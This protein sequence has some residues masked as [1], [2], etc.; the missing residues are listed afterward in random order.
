ERCLQKNRDERFSST[1]ELAAALREQSILI[2]VAGTGPTVAPTVKAADTRRLSLWITGLA[3]LFV[4][5][6]VSLWLSDSVRRLVIPSPDRAAVIPK[7]ENVV[8][9]PFHATGQQNLT[10]IF[11]DGLTESVTE[12]LT[13]LTILPSLQIAPASEVRGRQIQ[14]AE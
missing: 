4:V 11:A 10:Q 8:I 14:T 5:L 6:F 12:K 7:K 2:N 3:S 1:R 13:R 9:L